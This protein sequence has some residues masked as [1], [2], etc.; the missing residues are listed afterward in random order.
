MRKV[1]ATKGPGK[2]KLDKH[3]DEIIALL[4]NGSTKTFVA[5]KYESSVPNLYNWVKRH[6]IS[7][8]K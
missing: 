8:E 5:K 3:R 7:V 1:K 4:N 2:S 6:E